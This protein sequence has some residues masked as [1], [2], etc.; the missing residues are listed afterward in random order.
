MITLDITGFYYSCEVP[1]TGPDQTVFD[2]LKAAESVRGN[3]GG[4]LRVTRDDNNKF[5]ETLEVEFD[6]FPTTRQKTQDGS[7]ISIK[8]ERPK[9]PYIFTDDVSDK[10]NRIDKGGEIG[11]LTWQYYVFN[12]DGVP[13][14]NTG[15][16]RFI[17][18]AS[19]SNVGMEPIILEDGD[20][21][22]FRVVC[23]FGIAEL[24]DATLAVAAAAEK[25]GPITLKAAVDMMRSMEMTQEVEQAMQA[26]IER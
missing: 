17:T 15:L 11:L 4:K 24:I 5:V 19:S 14:P 18:P 6:T 3:N 1:F 20:R 12:K 23:I 22:T 16:T 10:A 21:I 26:A 7:A 9:G 2:V 25:V 8:T 13:K